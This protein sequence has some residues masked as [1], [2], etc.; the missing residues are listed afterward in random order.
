MAKGMSQKYNLNDELMKKNEELQGSL[1]VMGM[2]GMTQFS[3]NNSMRTVMLTSHLRQFLTLLNPDFPGIFTGMENVVGKR[4]S[5]YKKAKK[6][7]VVYKKIEKFPNFVDKPYIYKLFVY[8]EKQKKYDVITRKPTENLTEIF[9]FEYNNEFIDSLCEG[10]FV[11]KGSV[12]YKSTSYDE[13]MNYG[14]GVNAVVMLTLDPYTSEDAAIA[15][16]SLCKRLSSVETETVSI[17]VNDNHY[18]IN[19]RGDENHYQP[20][21]NL[22]EYVDG[23][24]AAKTTLY[25]NQVLCDF[26]DSNLNRINFTTDT[27]YYSK[28]EVVD[29]EIFCNKEELEMN[30]FNKQIIEY[31]DAQTEYYQQIN[32]TCREIMDSGEKYSH[33]IEYLYKRSKDFLNTE[34]KWTNGDGVFSNLIINIEVKR[35][36]EALVGQKTT[37]WLISP[38]I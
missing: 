21:P 19:L 27:V 30:S 23:I 6:D 36:Q 32:D 33:E 29:I 18:L 7:F 20:I 13:D 14:Y 31:Y 17:G 24:L 22:G 25:N 16:E 3:Y 28:G 2:S 38:S 35:V 34:Y 8:N 5:G 12:L 11:P 37:G 15:S 26:K 4:S 1:S 10:E 9:G